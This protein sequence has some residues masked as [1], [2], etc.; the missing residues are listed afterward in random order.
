MARGGVSSRST[1]ATDRIGRRELLALLGGAAAAWSAAA[2]AQPRI[3][4]VGLLYSQSADAIGHRLRAFRQGLKQHGFIEGET[5]SI[6]YRFAENQFDRLP[7][8]AADLVRRKVSAILAGN[9]IS[10][11]AVKAATSTIPVVFTVNEDP[12]RLG[13]VAS[14]AR[15]GGNMT[16]VNYMSAELAAKRLELIRELVPRAS[17]IGVLLNPT[18]PTNAETTRR[19]VEAA[20]RAIGLGARFVEVRSSAEIDRAFS[21]LARERPDA[22]FIGNDGLF[23]NRRV[24]LVHLTTRHGIPATYSSREYAEIGGLMS[25]GANI[26]EAWHQAGLYVGRILKG[27]KPLEL[28]VVQAAKFELVIN[29]QTARTLDL[30]VPPTLLAR[31][32]E[33]IE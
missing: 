21:V 1:G 16:G 32:D 12:V 27:T 33:V 4:V 14:D 20:A 26:P 10:A 11:L 23:T 19:D 18:N 7:A 31:A 6:V 5:V 3:P 24:Q 17:S 8:L 29:H 22:L 13:L 2:R 28:P 15:P 9:P 30:T 25:Y